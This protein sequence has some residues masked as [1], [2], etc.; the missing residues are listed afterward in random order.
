VRQVITN[1]VSNAIKFTDNGDVKV[2]L[3]YSSP[4][5]PVAVN[6]G[7]NHN[8]IEPSADQNS[9]E[10]THLEHLN[11]ADSNKLDRQPPIVIDVCD[12]GIGI[13]PEHQRTIFE[14]FRQVDQSSTRRHGGTGLGLAI[15]EQLVQMMGG[16]ISLIS[17]P[18]K[19]STFTVRLPS[20]YKKPF[21]TI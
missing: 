20:R 7:G 19:G 12:T 5:D 2:T 10:L 15:T 4:I 21:S 16:E 13:D 9:V 8:N 11:Q 14:Q 1:L 6:N 18:G 3:S 17:S